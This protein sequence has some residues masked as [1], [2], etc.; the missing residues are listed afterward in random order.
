MC[1]MP[2]IFVRNECKY[3]FSEVDN[4]HEH[5]HGAQQREML[6]AGSVAAVILL[7][8]G[9]GWWSLLPVPAFFWWY[10]IE[11]VVRLAKYRDQKE[12]Y[13]NI[14]FEQEAFINEGNFLYLVGRNG[15][16]WAK[17]L[18][19]KTYVHGS[20]GSKASLNSDNF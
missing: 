2:F 4:N 10:L 9:C 8:I 13:R 17:Y 6:M 1:L 15:F 18:F 14:S 11:Y 7:I 20:T 19:R 3:I 12:A 16:W 5:I